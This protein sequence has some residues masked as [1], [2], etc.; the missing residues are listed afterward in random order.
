[1]KCFWVR[2]VAALCWLGMVLE[3]QA[4][5][6]ISEFTA[7]NQRV[8]ADRD[9]DF[10]DWIELFNAGGTPVN[11]DGW[12]LTDL[13]SQP[14][15]W[16]FPAITIG[17][18]SF[19]VVFA[20]GKSRAT[21]N[22]ELHTSFS[23]DADGEYLA[24][25]RPGGTVESSFNPQFPEQFDDVSYGV[26]ADGTTFHY[27]SKPTPGAVNASGFL[28]FVAD[29]KF[30]HD[31]GFYEQPFDLTLSTATPG[32]TIC[33]TTNGLVPT[34]ANGLVYSTPIRI[35][36]T[37][38]LRARAFKDGYEPSNTDTHTYLFLED[39][40]RQSPDGAP[41]PG[42]PTSWGNNVRDYGMDPDV[43][44]NTLYRGTIKNDL[45]AVPSFSIVMDLRDL[46]DPTRGIYANAGQDGRAWERPTSLELINPDGTRGFQINAG[47]RIR[48]GFS[49]SSQ[50]PK[51]AF[52]LFFRSDYGDAKLKYPLFGDNGTDTFDAIDL[53]TF[54]NYSWS[55]QGDSR[56]IFVRDQFSR[57]AQLAMGHQGERG[58]YY[59]LYINGQYWGL[60]NTCERPEASFA[61]TYYGGSR[62][63]YDVIKVEAGPYTL[64][65]TDGT[66][67]AWTRLY[68]LAKGDLSND[69]LYQRLQGNNPDGTRNPAYENLIDVPNLI[70]YMLVIIYGGNLDAPISNFLGNT[71][72]NNWYGIR[73]RIGPHGFRFFAHDAEHTLLNV[74]E[75][76]TG[77]FPAGDTSVNYSSPQ[78]LMKRF[79]ANAE[80][81]M[82]F[83][84]HVH[85]H[86]FNNGIFTP[87]EARTLFLKR[88]AEIDRAVVG[89]SARWGDAKRAT[90]LTRTDWLNAVNGVL[91][92]FFPRRTSVVLT[93]LR[94][95]GLYPA[96]AAPTF[97]QHGGAIA[98]GYPL[99]MS[100][101]EGT[102]YYTLDG[103][104]PR[105]RGGERSSSARAYSGPV[106]LTESVRVKS[107]TQNGALW[108]ALNEA[109]FTIIQTFK[110]LFVT[111][112]MFNPPG[113]AGVDG[114]EFEFIELKNV[115]SADL[116]LS[117][118]NFTSG[119][120]FR[121]PNGTVLGP[122]Q[123]VVLASNA[124]QFQKRYP[125]VRVAGAYTGRLANAGER[126]TLVHA[127][128]D[129]IFTV[130]Y[131]DQP[132]WPPSADGAGFSLVPINP[133]LNLNPDD[134][135]QWRSSTRPGGSPGAD[136]PPP[137]NLG[138]AWIN[139]ILTHTDPPLVDTI[140]LH[141]PT[142]RFVDLS[143]WFLTDDRSVPKKFRIAPGTMI[144]PRGYLVLDE[145]QFNSSPGSP[146]SF[147]LN[148][149]G[150]E[151]YLFSAD[152]AGNLTGFSD[153]F[154]FAAAENGVS[155]GR[156]VTSTGEI[157]YPAQSL[158]TFGA[159]NAGPRIG[160]VIINE[161][162]YWPAGADVEF[163][164]L[165][166]MTAAPV[167]LSDPQ[168]PT[169][170][171]RLSG[172]NFEFPSG[173][174]LAGEGLLV[175]T[176]A[177][178][179]LFRAKYSVPANVPVLGPAPGALQD[180]GE[181]I[182]LKRPD[183]PDVLP[184][185][186]VIVPFIVVDAVRYN[187]KAPWPTNAAGGGA[188]LERISSTA[189]GNDPASWR[190]SPGPPSPG[191][192]NSG[193]RPP[194]VSAGL[195]ITLQ[196]GAFPVAAN[197]SGTALDDGMPRPPGALS[198]LWTQVSGPSLAQFTSPNQLATSVSF[199]TAGTF[200]FRLTVNDGALSSTD[201]VTV[202]VQRVATQVRLSPLGATWKYLDNGSNPETAWR[203]AA[204]NDSS[205]PSGRA[206]LGYGDG[207]EV[208][209]VRFGPN[210]ATKYVT[211][212][213]RRTFTAS[214]VA[215]ISELTLR[216]MRDDGA[217]VYLNGAE[218]F[219]SNMPE[220]E[221]TFSTRASAV[222]GGA[223]E[224]AFSDKQVDPS[225]L[226]EGSNLLAVEIHQSNVDS[227]DISFE[228]ELI[229]LVA[230][231]DDPYSAWKARYFN[232]AELSNPSISGDQADPDGDG[233]TN[234]QEFSAGTNPRD[235]ASVFKVTEIKALG[236]TVT[237]R[238]NAV[239]G[240][241]YSVET[242]DALAPGKAWQ[243]LV[244]INSAAA[245]GPI[246]VSDPGARGSE[247]RFYRVI[248]P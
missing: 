192:E 113:E 232:A 66:M 172:L 84:D 109:E 143:H 31:R 51:H 61:E 57:D 92:N 36:G 236:G 79:S 70:D 159:A 49:R 21:P 241:S 211:T 189:Y 37:T 48:G 201:T 115:S 121:F 100:A 146:T 23:L 85:R 40:I 155:F 239:A 173:T 63:D 229:G 161:I 3:G 42:W 138:A 242:R 145:S 141:N 5:V 167:L 119:I 215:S 67:A 112:I 122:G 140:E 25:V 43:V 83:A 72:P 226:V 180:N 102:I 216:V 178:P 206:Q 80:F 152:A 190:A 160:P 90:P 114:D 39:V 107:R 137:A 219:R 103:S 228:L 104:D 183:A 164:E 17:A 94:A 117:G 244:K 165:K 65:A 184:N 224:S 58:H 93:Q 81:R 54:Q 1:M 174:Q 101:P 148:S 194:Q 24:L 149:H 13:A 227:S 53:R 111:E 118:V 199:S 98:R 69:E 45:K 125:A 202:T 132:P 127:T 95:D 2:W 217:V 157:Q 129:A 12:S 10:P 47:I 133:N 91:N 200:E 88:T 124:E 207:D 33:Y 64:N 28:A 158:N 130:A 135:A 74:S 246:D 123:F 205:W 22:A 96:L 151:I 235:V 27:F 55:F 41:P 78:W 237:L 46:F 120:S 154:S 166:N 8:L 221:I 209:V 86:F 198:I 11:L 99:S 34:L 220:G 231:V 153:G 4:Q 131:S 38:V 50:N 108:S 193:N 142:E 19:L 195:D 222:V 247:S 181:L 196:A 150:E 176:T 116:D 9:G 97:G 225:L 139:E 110:D 243:T 162:H 44:N 56:G 208:T 14:A 233:Q 136:D 210:A 128:G 163:V 35:S 62:E 76:R 73:S 223:D 147:N 68:N 7:A 18:R 188:S 213:F 52:R 187:D 175:V 245:T 29:T 20:S 71:R 197:L 203:T 171:W 105:L 170:R 6:I 59:H 26:A 106:T 75:D 238:F 179:S 185:G 134:P 87:Q 214:N 144:A 169:N 240:R 168:F 60:F 156:H 191:L 248:S 230:P 204:F 30:S 212:Y 177:D 234:A 32:A 186:A 77:P 89:E 182:E 218:V 15:K 16:Q 82:L 126:I